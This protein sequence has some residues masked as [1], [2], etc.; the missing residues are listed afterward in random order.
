[1]RSFITLLAST[2]VAKNAVPSLWDGTCFYP[3]PDIGFEL[4]SY[5]G[6]WY[7]IAGTNAPYTANCKCVFAEYKLNDNGTVYVNNNCQVGNKPVNIRG[8]ATP[9]NPEYGAS[10]VFRVQFPVEIPPDCLGPNYIVQDYTGDFSLVLS[11]NFTTLFI[12]SRKQHPDE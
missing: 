8:T 9:A 7:Q 12:L 10:G 6:R 11:N 3:K 1:M 5:L 4:E 2:V